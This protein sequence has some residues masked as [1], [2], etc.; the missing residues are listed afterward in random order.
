[1]YFLSPKKKKKK[2]R[3]WMYLPSRMVSNLMSCS[4]FGRMACLDEEG[5]EGK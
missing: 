4:R 1:M 3:S 2:R 5:K